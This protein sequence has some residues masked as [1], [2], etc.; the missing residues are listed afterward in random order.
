[1][2]CSEQG[3]WRD[4]NLNAAV[5]YIKLNKD[6]PRSDWDPKKTQT[7]HLQSQNNNLPGTEE[8]YI[9]YNMLESINI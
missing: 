8:T 2:L 7:E 3:R 5:F 9:K 6:N 4:E 1:M